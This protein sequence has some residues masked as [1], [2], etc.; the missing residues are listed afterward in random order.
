M[1]D[2]FVEEIEAYRSSGKEAPKEMLAIWDWQHEEIMV[3]IADTKILIDM[4]KR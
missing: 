1:D 2:K 3:E 4:Y